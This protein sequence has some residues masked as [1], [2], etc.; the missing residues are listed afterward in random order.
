MVIM[1]VGLNYRL[2]ERKAP[3]EKE[4]HQE[5]DLNIMKSSSV[6][7]KE[8]SGRLGSFLDKEKV[9]EKVFV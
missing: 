2:K 5:E 6:L 3:Q 8:K 9:E 1:M 4:V 7:Y